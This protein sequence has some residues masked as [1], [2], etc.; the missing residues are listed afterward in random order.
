MT[1][2]LCET[3]VMVDW[4]DPAVATGLPDEAPV[5]AISV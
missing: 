2:G 3:S 4:N 1:T 5:C